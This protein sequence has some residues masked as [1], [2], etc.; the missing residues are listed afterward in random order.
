MVGG[1]VVFFAKLDIKS[2]FPSIPWWAV[3]AALL[4]YGYGASFAS[5]VMALVQAR[6]VERRQGR[7]H[8]LAVSRGLQQGLAESAVLA[9]M[10]PWELDHD[11]MRPGRGLCYRR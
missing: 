11:L 5:F 2:Y 8:D 9:N 6:V 4:H 1:Q 10:V 7:W 3:E